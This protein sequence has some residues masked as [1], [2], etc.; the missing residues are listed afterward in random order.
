MNPTTAQI[1]IAAYGFWAIHLTTSCCMTFPPIRTYQRNQLRIP[2][3]RFLP[4]TYPT[5]AAINTAM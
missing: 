2:V 3:L 4:M 5:P 1:A